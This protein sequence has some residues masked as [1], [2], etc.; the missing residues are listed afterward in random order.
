MYR[1]D[2]SRYA[3]GVPHFGPVDAGAGLRALAAQNLEQ[4]R[5]AEQTRQFNTGHEQRQKEHNDQVLHQ[6]RVSTDINTRFATQEANEIQRA[7]HGEAMKN[8]QS[9]QSD[10]DKARQLV[11][12]GR[13]NEAMALA[14]GLKDRGA[15]VTITTGP[16]GRPNFELSSGQFQGPQLEG[17]F[18][19]IIGRF[20]GQPQSPQLDFQNN[21]YE[22]NLPTTAASLHVQQSNQDPPVGQEPSEPSNFGYDQQTQGMIDRLQQDVSAL[23]QSSIGQV[24][25]E[26][27]IDPNRLDTSQLSDWTAMR[28]NPVLSGIQAGI[29]QR[30]S[31]M[32]GAFLQ[33][34][35]SLGQTPEQTL[36]TLQ[37]PF[38]TLAGLWRGE[39]AA[40]SA[41]A[42]ASMSQSGQE[43]NRD[44]RVKGMGWQQMNNI[45]SQLK[46]GEV[47]RQYTDIDQIDRMLSENN[48]MADSQ[49][50][51]AIRG[52]FQSGVATQ[53][54]IDAVK[55]GIK[56]FVQRVSDFADEQILGT[57]L[58]PD[59]RAGLRRF[60]G[61]LKQ[62]RA[63]Q[64]L[65]GASQM[66]SL[67]D[68]ADS[69]EEAKSNFRYMSSI[70]PKSLWSE[71]MK[72]YSE[73]FSGGIEEKPSM[74]GPGPSRSS[75]SASARG[76]GASATV[77][78]PPE[79]NMD[80]DEQAERL[81]MEQ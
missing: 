47:N 21:P 14:G 81:F 40:E 6:D 28:L 75:A 54:D 22:P 36:E 5:M 67:L 78:V 57:G 65:N 79:A 73:M 4:Q 74:R 44:L 30:Y 48:P 49:I 16:D 52:L 20:G 38:N 46:L 31:G 64:L 23:P 1:V 61:S 37:N 42:R 34:F 53:K 2:F 58:N 26:N 63:S 80:P 29:P 56:P 10:L 25:Q 27:E 9:L 13:W 77:E 69:F 33:G 60:M 35:K 55:S 76:A 66:E 19:S 50:L 15:D 18:E 3:Q 51:H 70:I 71:K 17:S 12:S 62:A 72:K 59:S 24:Q 68:T 32:G 41:M 11:V 39:M 7:R 8:F 45:A 43:S